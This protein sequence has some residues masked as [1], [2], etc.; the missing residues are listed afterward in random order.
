MKENKREIERIEAKKE[1]TEKKRESVR[2][3]RTERYIKRDQNTVRKRL[4]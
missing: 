2:E 3:T 1:N 4:I